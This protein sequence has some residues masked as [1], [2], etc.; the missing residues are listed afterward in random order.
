MARLFSERRYFELQKLLG[1]ET[2]PP[3]PE[4]LF[5]RGILANAFNRLNDSIGYLTAYLQTP[6]AAR[7]GTRIREA[8]GA[9]ADDYT[10]LFQYGKASE[11]RER[12][13]P[14]LQKELPPS[15]Y[16]AFET[17]VDFGKAMASAPPQTVDIPGDTETI[18][19]EFSEIP[20]S[21]EGRDI[22]LLADTGSALSLIIVSD[23]RRLGFRILDVEVQVGTSTGES[24]RAR[25]CL[26]PELRIGAIRVFNAVFLVVPDKMF[27]SREL[28][29]QR[30]GLLG[31]PVLN[32][33]R[34]ITFSPRGT[35]VVSSPPRLAGPPNYFLE[36]HNPVLEASFRG[37]R[38][39]FLLDTG[40]YQSE[41][42]P[43]FYR[44]FR[45][46][47]ETKGTYAPEDIEGVGTH[48]TVPVYLMK[49]LGFDIGGREVVFNKELPILTKPTNEASDVYDGTFSLDLMGTSHPL[50]I[51][52]AAMRIALR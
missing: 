22:F 18:L 39:L 25:P 52:Y 24:V 13:A 28:K 36:R 11:T 4:D 43:S 14:L 40:A 16:A 19:T 45:P 41:L 51:S 6:E 27:Y 8:L 3:R 49:G 20:V 46:E 48:I 34:E 10:K 47:I 1:P 44:A 50:T 5:Y 21:F 17:V 2:S 32:A 23:A 42:F 31:F 35:F 30:S 7:P 33:L 38:L 29:R 12:I 26:V 15:D 37:R 9:L